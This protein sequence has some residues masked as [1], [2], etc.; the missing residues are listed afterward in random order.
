[1]IRVWNYNK[2]RIYST[3]GVKDIDILLDDSLIF[4]GEISKAP[5]WMTDAD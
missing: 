3:R 2:S 4:K 1:M 5:G